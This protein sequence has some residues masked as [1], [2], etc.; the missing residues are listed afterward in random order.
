[1]FCK[2]WMEDLLASDALCREGMEM[3]IRGPPRISNSVVLNLPL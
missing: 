2:V 3:Q 1:M